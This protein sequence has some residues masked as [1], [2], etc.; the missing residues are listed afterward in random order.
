MG[1][2]EDLVDANTE[3]SM[4]FINMGE[5]YN[6]N[7]TVIYN[8]FSSIIS[9]TI[10]NDNLDQ[11]PKSI[12]EYWKRS[13]WVRWKQAIE[14]EFDSLNKRQFFGSIHTDKPKTWCVKYT[15]M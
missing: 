7:I 5:T 4:N 11:E 13:D 8:I 6:T 3:V 1:N 12:A 9:L 14:T 2:D 10:L 15:P